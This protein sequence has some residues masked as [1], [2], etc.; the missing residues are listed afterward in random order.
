MESDIIIQKAKSLQVQYP[1]RLSG[2]RESAV[3][4]G[5]ENGAKFSLARNGTPVRNWSGVYRLFLEGEEAGKDSLEADFARTFGQPMSRG[6]S[7]LFPE[8]TECQWSSD[9][10]DKK[11]NKQ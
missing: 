7:R 9:E 1:F 3:W 6:Q 11:I 4:S 2:L 10:V 8:L 5:E